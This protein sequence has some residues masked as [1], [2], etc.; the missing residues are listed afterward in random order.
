MNIQ[1]LS[2]E[3]WM[4]K[5]KTEIKLERIL[6]KYDG[7][8]TGLQDLT[9]GEAPSKLFYILADKLSYL[10]DN[11]PDK[12]I[13]AKD[14]I[15]CRKYS[16]IIKSIA[17]HFL[18][19]SQI[20]ENRNFLNNPYLTDVPPDMEIKLPQEPVI[21]AA[22]HGFKDDILATVL[23]AKRHAFIMFGGLPQFYNTIDGI[24]DRD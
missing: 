5:D 13:L 12:A 1:I 21:W 19:N 9:A 8:I 20:F 15:R 23:A 6:Q 10:L 2:G 17:T 4:A 18:A 7:V 14:I 22:N 16:P 11:D 3:N 24:F